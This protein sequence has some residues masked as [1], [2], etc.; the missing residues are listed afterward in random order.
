MR[1]AID[2]NDVVRDYTDNFIKVYLMNYNHEY[3]PSQLDL[4]TNDMAEVLPFKS[5]RAYQNF[6][7]T[8]FPYELFGKVDVCTRGLAA[9]IKQWMS[10]LR[11]ME[12]EE[13]IEVI[14]VSPMEY[15]ASINYTYFFIS[16]LGC[17]VREVYLPMDSAT[18]WDK[19]DVLIT[20]NPS[21]LGSK[22]EGKKTV[23]IK[24]DYNE[25]NAG[26]MELN[27]L[28]AFISDENNIKKLT[29][30]VR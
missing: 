16:K 10:S 27:S 4:W 29:E 25:K 17:D 9:E 18:I 20:A 6:V 28:S 21:L 24:K 1:I 8:D 30:N 2:L 5:D 3:D 11:E 23:K 14:F 13:E 15:G 7:Y 22:P 19:C 12:T 26:D